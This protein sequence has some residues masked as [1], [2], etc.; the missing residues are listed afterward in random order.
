MESIFNDSI[1]NLFKSN[2]FNHTLIEKIS[3]YYIGFLLAHNYF[4]AL[5]DYLKVYPNKYI[6]KDFKAQVVS[7][8]QIKTIKGIKIIWT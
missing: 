3:N 7:G 8:E 4:T 5:S 2:H 1:F 6:D